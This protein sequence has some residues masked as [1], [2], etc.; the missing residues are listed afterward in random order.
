MRPMRSRLSI[1]TVDAI[2]R[3][4][5]GRRVRNGLTTAFVALMCDSK[6]IEKFSFEMSEMR[7]VESKGFYALGIRAKS[8]VSNAIRITSDVCY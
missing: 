4:R 1:E 8:F 5:T 3:I 7:Q 6:A 2:P